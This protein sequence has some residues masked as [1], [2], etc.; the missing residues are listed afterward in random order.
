VGANALDRRRMFSQ[1]N[2]FTVVFLLIGQLT[3]IGQIITTVGITTTI[4]E[5]LVVSLANMTAISIWPTWMV[6]EISETL[7]KVF[8]YVLMRPGKEGSFHCC[9]TR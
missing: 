9:Y 6:V 2:S 5:T 8:N 3:L 1:V 7:R 4:C